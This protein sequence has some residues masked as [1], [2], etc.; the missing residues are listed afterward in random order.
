MAGVVVPKCRPIRTDHET[1]A[2]GAGRG[3][4]GER[5]FK[6]KCP[7]WRPETTQGSH[8]VKSIFSHPKE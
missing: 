4:G 3:G 8:E 6:S 7:V 5:D 1:L 2:E